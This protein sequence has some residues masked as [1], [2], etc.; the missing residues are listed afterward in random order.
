MTTSEGK[1]QPKLFKAKQQHNK[2]IQFVRFLIEKTLRHHKAFFLGAPLSYRKRLTFKILLLL[3]LI[4]NI[5]S[6]CRHNRSYNEILMSLLFVLS[7]KH[8]QFFKL[9]KQM[10][11]F[12]FENAT[13][14]KK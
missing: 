5:S 6:T 2:S 3:T 4:Q 1:S 10:L 7:K 12:F 8:E 13:T 9:K 11:S 14:T